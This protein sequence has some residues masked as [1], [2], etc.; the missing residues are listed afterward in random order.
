MG[1]DIARLDAQLNHDIERALQMWDPTD[2]KGSK[3]KL[4]AD[5]IATTLV[6]VH[7]QTLQNIL[8][9]VHPI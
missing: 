3:D 6:E 5:G 9:E 1:A 8:A 4:A 7:N 2:P